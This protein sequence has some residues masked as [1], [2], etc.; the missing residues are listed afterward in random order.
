MSEVRLESPYLLFLGDVQDRIMAKTAAGVAY[1]RPDICVGEVSLPDCTVTLGL[2]KVTP[3][4]GGALGARTLVVGVANAGGHI[5]EAWTGLLL[6]ALESGL[7]IAS[8]L[9]SRIADV[10]VLAEAAQRLGRRIDDIRHPRQPIPIGRGS[11]RSGRRLLTVGT[12]C[13][14][15]KMYASLAIARELNNR[16]VNARFRATGQTG[17]FITGE[18]V[19]VDAVV[20]DFI[21]GSVEALSPAMPADQWDVIEG[22]GSLFHPAYAGVTLGL[23]HGSQPDAVVVCH[24]AGRDRMHEFEDF[25]TP[26]LELAI[27]RNLEAARLTNPQVR[28]VGVSMNTS[29]LAP[30]DAH[31]LMTATSRALGLPCVDPVRTGVAPIVD[32]LLA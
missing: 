3:S 2:P 28:C 26:S 13:A 19:C 21:S 22:Q 8:G 7:D 14:V 30:E 5:S 29:R 25:A 17:I 20:S 18:G 1:W 15:G 6:E 11:P 32:R 4:Q 16:G 9:H 10:P 27:A 31:T 24:E 12:D 23:I